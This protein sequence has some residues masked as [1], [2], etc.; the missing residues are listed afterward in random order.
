MMSDQDE[1]EPSEKAHIEQAIDAEEHEIIEPK[2]EPPKKINPGK[3]SEFKPAIVLD[4]LTNE[5]TFLPNVGDTVLIEY[6]TQSWREDTWCKIS[7]IDQTTGHLD[8]YD[9]K[10]E[11][12]IG[13]NF[14]EAAKHSVFMWIPP[15]GSRVKR[16][17]KARAKKEK[18]KQHDVVRKMKVE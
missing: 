4:P 14:K 5:Y 6:R 17:R 13:S 1:T 10:R 18:H 16:P 8:L 11:Y 15:A 7:K 3:S 12:H 9:I 2:D